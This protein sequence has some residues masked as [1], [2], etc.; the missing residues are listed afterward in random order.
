M[1]FTA[2]P[3]GRSSVRTARAAY[4]PCVLVVD[5]DPFVC[6]FVRTALKGAGYRTLGASDLDSALALFESARPRVSVAVLDVSMPGGD[7]PD[8]LREL[9]WSRPNLPAIFMSG[10]LDPE[11]SNELADR[12]RAEGATALLAKPMRASDLCAAVAAALADGS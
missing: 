10:E 3:L 6:S 12:L 1:T 9:R 8:L 2:P 11:L 5:D 4:E 7:G